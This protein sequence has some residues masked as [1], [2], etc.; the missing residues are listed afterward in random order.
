MCDTRRR[1]RDLSSY[2]DQLTPA[3]RDALAGVVRNQ[4]HRT[5]LRE[6]GASPLTKSNY[7]LLFSEERLLEH[8]AEAFVLRFAQHPITNGVAEGLHSKI[9]SIKR[10]GRCLMLR[11]SE[12]ANEDAQVVYVSQWPQLLTDKREEQAKVDRRAISYTGAM[13]SRVATDVSQT[14]ARRL[15]AMTPAE[16]ITLARRLGDE[17]VA[18]YMTTHGVDRRTAIVRIKATHQVGRRPSRCTAADES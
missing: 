8:H 7:L 10:K 4:A 6:T 1:R 16:R 3:Q 17:G 14:R 2:H 15:A 11:S 13:R 5:C 9:M 18:A 12:T